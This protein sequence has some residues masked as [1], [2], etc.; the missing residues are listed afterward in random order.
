MTE[1]SPTSARSAE[2]AY[3]LLGACAYRQAQLC[4]GAEAEEERDANLHPEHRAPLLALATTATSM[5]TVSNK[6][7]ERLL[8]YG[9]DTTEPSLAGHPT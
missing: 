9:Y 1:P 5:P 6:V 3:R 7:T 4:A 8:K 2:H